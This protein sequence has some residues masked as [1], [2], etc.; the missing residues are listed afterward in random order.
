MVYTVSIKYRNF[1]ELGNWVLCSPVIGI[2]KIWKI[3]LIQKIGQLWQFGIPFYLLTPLFAD[4]F[5]ELTNQFNT[6]F[7]TGKCINKII[8][9]IC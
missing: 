9:A 7:K 4:K 3:F 8:E 5:K 1:Y 6:L 2:W